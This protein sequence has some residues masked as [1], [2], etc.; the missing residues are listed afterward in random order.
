MLRFRLEELA[1]RN[2]EIDPRGRLVQAG[3][4]PKGLPLIFF[5]PSGTIRRF[6]RFGSM[7]CKCVRSQKGVVQPLAVSE[8][9]NVVNGFLRGTWKAGRPG[10]GGTG[11]GMGFK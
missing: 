4:T 7:A 9:F 3:R 10:A 1:A 5:C 6:G 2:E 11:I 8:L